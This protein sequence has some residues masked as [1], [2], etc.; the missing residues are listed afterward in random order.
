MDVV[1][2]TQR[3]VRGEVLGE[4]KLAMATYQADLAWPI[5]FTS[6]DQVVGK[7]ARFSMEPYTVVTSALV[8][9]VADR[10]QGSDDALFIESGM[11]AVSIPVSR[12][13][14]ISYA[15]A[16]GD[17]VNVIV[18]LALVD[19]DPDFQ[20]VLPNLTGNVIAPGGGAV[21]GGSCVGCDD[22]RR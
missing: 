20:T 15:P 22:P 7:I 8:T 1:V 21:V 4:D 14:S 10:E 17:R 16:R 11:V 19:I 6:I 12:L 2:V 3:V 13:S 18:T 9:D 5:M